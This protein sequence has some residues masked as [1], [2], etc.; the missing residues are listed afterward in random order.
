M[1]YK[2]M[3]GYTEFIFEAFDMLVYFLKVLITAGMEN[4]F[5]HNNQPQF[6]QCTVFTSVNIHTEVVQFFALVILVV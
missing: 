1:S 6:I 3:F 2:S 5:L 4:L